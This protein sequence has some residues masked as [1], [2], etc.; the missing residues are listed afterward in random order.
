MDRDV[1]VY[2]VYRKLKAIA[3]LPIISVTSSFSYVEL[4][5]QCSWLAWL[6]TA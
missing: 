6:T 5:L 1:V 2:I 4:R 3:Y